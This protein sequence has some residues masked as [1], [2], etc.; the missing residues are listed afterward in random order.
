MSDLLLSNG[1]GYE[2]VWLIKGD[3]QMC[4]DLTKA[5]AIAT[6][7]EDKRLTIRLPQPQAQH[8][9]VD[10]SRSKQFDLKSRSLTNYLGFGDR[11]VHVSE[12]MQ[13]AQKMVEQLCQSEEL[14]NQARLSAEQVL[15]RMYAMVDWTIEIEWDQPVP[16]ASQP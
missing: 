8:P 1:K 16:I 3:C 5:E 7:I 6:S 4:V 9:R 14:S 15:A 11:A 12:A 2:G 13:Q 10:H